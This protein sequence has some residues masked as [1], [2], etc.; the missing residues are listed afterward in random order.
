MTVASKVPSVLA[1]DAFVEV[2]K[3]WL[4]VSAFGNDAGLV[5]VATLAGGPLNESVEFAS[6]VPTVVPAL[7]AAT[8][9]LVLEVPIE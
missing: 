7:T 5:F 4:A 6:G 8:L 9:I 3:G 1:E 2:S